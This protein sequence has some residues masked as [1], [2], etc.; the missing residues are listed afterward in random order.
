M[1][2]QVQELKRVVFEELRLPE[3]GTGLGGD[4]RAA[5]REWLTPED[6]AVEAA[7]VRCR[8]Q[9]ETLQRLAERVGTVPGGYPRHVDWVMR[10]I[11]AL[12][13][14]YTRPLRQFCEE[15][16]EQARRVSE[17]LERM[18]RLQIEMQ[19]RQ[20]GQRETAVERCESTS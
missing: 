14:W 13:P 18:H 17:A 15:G 2:R 5:R 9:A 20:M 1:R 4:R 16:A 19:D 10:V 12:L 11:A 6:L 3:P 8:E 7:V